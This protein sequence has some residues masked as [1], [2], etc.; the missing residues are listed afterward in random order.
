MQKNRIHAFNSVWC[1]VLEI[2]AH[3]VAFKTYI[4]LH[5]IVCVLI[6]ITS[7]PIASHSMFLYEDIQKLT[8]FVL[9]VLNS[10]TGNKHV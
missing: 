4:I 1:I 5:T 6:L 8:I 2:C 9:K 10:F 3:L 7:S